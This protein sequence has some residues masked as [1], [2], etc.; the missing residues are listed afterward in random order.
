LTSWKGDHRGALAQ[1]V[2][3]LDDTA[4]GGRVGGDGVDQELGDRH[5]RRCLVVDE[6]VG[7]AVVALAELLLA[8]VAAQARGCEVVERAA[9][10]NALELRR[11]RGEEGRRQIEVG[12]DAW[13]ARGDEHVKVPAAHDGP[14]GGHGQRDRHE[15]AVGVGSVR[16]PGCVRPLG[17]LDELA[18]QEHHLSQLSALEVEALVGCV[19]FDLGSTTT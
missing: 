17:V 18:E 8:L 16:Q 4:I 19:A 7:D 5:A 12:L 3:G 13:V 14:R 11:A 1:V 10:L 15:A 9:G 6:A 2:I